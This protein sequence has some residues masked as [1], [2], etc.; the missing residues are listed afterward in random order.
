MDALRWAQ[1][2]IENR[3]ITLDHAIKRADGGRP[4]GIGPT[5]TGNRR[6]VEMT[7]CCWQPCTAIASNKPNAAW[8][9]PASG[10]PTLVGPI[11][12]SPRRSGTP[13]DPSHAR[14]DFK[15]ICATPAC[16]ALS[17]YE[18]RH[19]VAS[20]MVDADVPLREV[21]AMTRRTATVPD[22]APDYLTVDEVAAIKR[23]SRGRAYAQVRLGVATNGEDGIPAERVDKQFRI[24]KYVIEEQLGGPITWPIPGFHDCAEVPSDEASVEPPVPQ[25]ASMS[26]TTPPKPTR[27]SARSRPTLS[28]TPSSGSSPRRSPCSNSTPSE[29]PALQRQTSA[30]TSRGPSRDLPTRR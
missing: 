18:M 25:P 26:D 13:I 14:R 27:R 5:K 6:D 29:P 10:R 28:P 7:D 9:R 8:P 4:L 20:L 11:S 30:Q 3:T 17:L 19:T 12:C 23:I 24:S 22:E 2:D 15:K 1:V 16:P 21:E